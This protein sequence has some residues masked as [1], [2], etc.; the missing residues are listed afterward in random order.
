M[1]TQNKIVGNSGWCYL[2]TVLTSLLMLASCVPTT[3]NTTGS[4]SVRPT[5]A[6]DEIVKLATKVETT[7]DPI[8]AELLIEKSKGFI[9]ENSKYKDVDE[10]YYIRTYAISIFKVGDFSC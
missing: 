2:L 5:D 3:V 7:A 10:V 4:S 8:D 1:I 9:D 6:Y